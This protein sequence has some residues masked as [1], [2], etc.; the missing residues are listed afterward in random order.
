MG[1][2]AKTGAIREGALAVATTARIKSSLMQGA[3]MATMLCA[4]P[5]AAQT[6]N[7]IPTREQIQQPSLP[8][9]LP[10]REQIVTADDAIERAPCP[11]A[12]P[13]Y[14]KLRF[15]LRGV[16]FG[17]SQVVDSAKLSPAWQGLLGQDLSLSAVCDI[18][19]HAATILRRNGYLAAVQVPPQ[20]IQDGIIRLDILTA[21][22]AR[23]EVRGDA[24]PNA[25]LLQ[26]YLSHLEEQPAFNL[27]DAERYLLMAREIP[28]MDARLTLRPGTVAGEVIG[29]VQVARMPYLFDFGIQNYGTRD[30][31]RWSGVAR[32]QI[33][34]I[35]GMGDLTTLSFYGTPDLDEQ[36]VVQ[37]AHEF[38]IG[39]EGWRVGGSYSYAWTRPDIQG[40]NL[41]SNAQIVSLYT[42]YPL[43]L[44]QA[45]R[46]SVGGGIDFI[47]QD[48][49]LGPLALNRDRLRVVNARMDAAW[50][51]AL[52]ISGRN[53]YSAAEPRWMVQTSVEARKGLSGFGASEGCGVNGAGCLGV[54]QV[55]VSRIEGKADA[56]LVRGSVQSEIRPHP[57]FTFAMTTRGQWAFDPLLSYEEFSGGNFTIG[58][59]YDAGTVIGDSGIATALEAR[60]STGMQLG[61]KWL[62][63]S[64][65]AFFDAARV[66]NKDRA[67][68][69][70]DRQDI[71]S[72]GVGLR[73]SMPPIGRLDLTY[74]APL[75][76][77]GLSD[78]KPDPRLLVSFSTYFGVRAR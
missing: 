22:L 66:W 62:S 38:R 24:G 71:Y 52:S 69:G 56:F 54:G 48:I 5:V 57:K 23:I 40:L 45:H 55:P 13:E 61:K 75:T 67:L 53:G 30:V 59:G 3:A 27:V 46:L 39:D 33:A 11:L 73:A 76:R 78:E 8:T 20:T 37:I 34:G 65:F 60:Y 17:G 63:L 25:G 42:S 16:E 28:G 43:T 2:K 4:S 32:A 6:P 70:L 74:A 58:R 36:K 26:R 41:K 1:A 51:D 31:G 9:T 72:A 35:T 12:N 7:I 29:E 68:R 14:A 77:A 64:P 10:R 15:T 19:D 44:R 49:A 21:R 50:S 18:R 47:N